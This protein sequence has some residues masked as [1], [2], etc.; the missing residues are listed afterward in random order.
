M[1]GVYHLQA[2]PLL[3]ETLLKSDSFSGRANHYLLRIWPVIGSHA[4]WH[5]PTSIH[6]WIAL[7]ELRESSKNKIRMEKYHRGIGEIWR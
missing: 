5:G 2:L 3:T 1:Y 6:I 7:T 4:S